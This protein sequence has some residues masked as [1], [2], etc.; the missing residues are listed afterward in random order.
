ME[1]C[2]YNMV[3][4][5]LMELLIR[6]RVKSESNDNVSYIVKIVKKGVLSRKYKNEV[7]KNFLYKCECPSKKVV[8][9]KNIRYIMCT[10]SVKKKTSISLFF[11]KS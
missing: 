6:F 5:N 9:F 1:L 10:F 7:Y 11:I 3:F 4:Y 8:I 2:A